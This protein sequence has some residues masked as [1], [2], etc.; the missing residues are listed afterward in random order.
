MARQKKISEGTS[1]RPTSVEQ[2]QILD[3]IVQTSI[4]ETLVIK[5]SGEYKVLH[6]IFADINNHIVD[7]KPGDVISLT[8]WEAKVLKNYIEEL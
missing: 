2:S 7:A 4:K 3:E 8:G 5:Q 6:D 1:I